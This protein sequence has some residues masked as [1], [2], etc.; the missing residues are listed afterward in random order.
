MQL[1]K[2]EGF[3][4]IYQTDS[5]D[6][7]YR[8][9]FGHGGDYK[10]YE[11]KFLHNLKVLDESSSINHAL[12]LQTFELIDKNDHIYSIRHVSGRNPRVLF[13]HEVDDG[14]YVLLCSFLEKGDSDYD[15]AVKRAKA[16]LK[17]LN[18]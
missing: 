1:V 16:I 4:K 11:K 15:K 13:F 5:F 8:K 14:N 3:Q 18:R 2:R 12:L 17:E 7:D 6:K 10:V 9:L